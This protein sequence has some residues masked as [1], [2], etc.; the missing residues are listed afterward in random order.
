M[1]LREQQLHSKET[2]AKISDVKESCNIE[3]NQRSRENNRSTSL[4]KQH[5]E[6]FCQ[7]E[8]LGI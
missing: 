1:T 5:S 8:R 2:V 3:E 4:E 6:I 7:F